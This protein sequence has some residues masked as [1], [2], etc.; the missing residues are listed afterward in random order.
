MRQMIAL[1]GG[2]FS[3]EHA[4]V[5]GLLFDTAAPKFTALLSE[6]FLRL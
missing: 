4:G 3:E 1:G 5:H 6:G 2:G